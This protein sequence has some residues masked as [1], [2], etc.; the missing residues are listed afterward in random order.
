LTDFLA[1]DLGLLSLGGG[2]FFKLVGG[3]LTPPAAA[4]AGRFFLWFEEG[5]AFSF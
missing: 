5:V 2:L 4:A 3:V 1:G